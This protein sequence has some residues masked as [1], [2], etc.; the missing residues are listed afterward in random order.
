MHQAMMPIFE[1]NVILYQNV[2]IKFRLEVFPLTHSRRITM[3]DAGLPSTRP[4]LTTPV[5]STTTESENTMEASMA[6]L[7]YGIDIFQSRFSPL[8]PCGFTTHPILKRPSQNK[9]YTLNNCTLL[10]PQNTQLNITP[11]HSQYHFIGHSLFSVGLKLSDVCHPI[12][13]AGAFHKE[14]NNLK[15]APPLSP[16][17]IHHGLPIYSIHHYNQIICSITLPMYSRRELRHLADE[18]IIN[19]LDHAIHYAQDPHYQKRLFEIFDYYGAFVCSGFLYG[20]F[21]RQESSIITDTP[22]DMSVLASAAY[23]EKIGAHISL[24]E[25]QY[26]DFSDYRRCTHFSFSGGD[27]YVQ[28]KIG[29]GHRTQK[30][31]TFNHWVRNL[32]NDIHL[33]FVDFTPKGMIPL[34]YLAKN[35]EE[36]KLIARAFETWYIQT[37]LDRSLLP[38]VLTDVTVLEKDHP[39]AHDDNAGFSHRTPLINSTN[40]RYLYIGY[41]KEPAHHVLKNQRAVVTELKISTWK[42][43]SDT[44][45]QQ[46]TLTTSNVP[47]FVHGCNQYGQPAD[48][49]PGAPHPLWGIRL[50]I[51]VEKL[52]WKN[53]T[54]CLQDLN[55]T[56]GPY[57]WTASI[58]SYQKINYNLAIAPHTAN[59]YYAYLNYLPLV[60]RPM[61]DIISKESVFA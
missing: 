29:R 12:L 40:Q 31:T 7:G 11:G 19:I 51:K 24:R 36:S 38:D 60:D 35:N 33:G 45:S 5:M 42:K 49:T 9:S 21:I 52:S 58:P 54:H 48:L 26:L 14:L 50:D 18:N 22:Y 37:I 1:N 47:L 30:E 20:G 10:L 55:I 4:P 41:N 56:T 32:H 57:E 34:W 46:G 15:N 27:P 13:S 61:Y 43:L 8:G 53:L 2:V 59:H 6:L 25:L 23:K 39:L 16:K 28:G 17:S 44:V 3:Q